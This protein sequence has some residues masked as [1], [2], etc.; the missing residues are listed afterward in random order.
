MRHSVTD[1]T[2]PPAE[3]EGLTSAEVITNWR[4]EVDIDWQL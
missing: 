1:A 4:G 3:V 2:H